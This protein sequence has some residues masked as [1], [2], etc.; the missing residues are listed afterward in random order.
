MKRG[1]Q[2]W[3]KGKTRSFYIKKHREDEFAVRFGH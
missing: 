3:A 2:D 1:G